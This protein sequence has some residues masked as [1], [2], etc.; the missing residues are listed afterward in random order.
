MTLFA[1]NLPVSKKDLDDTASSFGEAFAN[2][3]DA[4]RVAQGGVLGGN[5]ALTTQVLMATYNSGG[6]A[7]FASCGDGNVVE[8]YA[9]GADFSA[10]TVAHRFFMSKGERRTQGGLSNGAIFVSTKG[11]S[12][13]SNCADTNSTQN[14]AGVMPFGAE[15][16]ADRQFFFFAFRDSSQTGSGNADV[17]QVFVAA[18]AVPSVVELKNGTG[19]TTVAGPVSLEAFGFTTLQTNADA[20]FQVVATQPVFCAV[21]AEFRA[22]NSGNTAFEDM[23]LIPP[24]TTDLLTHVSNNRLSALYDNTIVYAYMQDGAIGR[25]TVSPGSPVSLYTGTINELGDVFDITSNATPATAGTFKLSL[26]SVDAAVLFSAAPNTTFNSFDGVV[27]SSNTI[28]RCSITTPSSA[29]TATP[30]QVIWESGGTGSGVSLILDS[31]MQLGLFAGAAA[32]SPKLVSTTALAVDTDYDII[33]ELISGTSL[34]IHVQPASNFDWWSSGRTPEYTTSD[35]TTDYA[36]TDGGGYGVQNGTFGGYSGSTSGTISFQGALNSDLAIFAN[37]ATAAQLAMDEITIPYDNAGV[38]SLFDTALGSDNSKV[39][40]IKGDSLADASAV[41]RVE[42]FGDYSRNSIGVVLD[43]SGL[44]GNAHT[45]SLRQ[46]GDTINNFGSGGS[47]AVN[48]LVRLISSGPISALSGA[49]GSGNEATYA[50]PTAQAYQLTAIPLRN[51]S[52]GNTA[53]SSGMTFLSYAEDEVKIY[54]SDGSLF[55]TEDM[56]R[57]ISVSTAAD[58]L[59]PAGVTITIDSDGT[60]A[61]TFSGGWAESNSPFVMIHNASNSDEYGSL[62]VDEVRMGGEETVYLG[63]TPEDIRA[64]IRKDADGILRARKI[65]A[66]GVETWEVI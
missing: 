24:L 62:P 34:N 54:N 37:T 60:P 63:I 42:L 46:A 55:A 17:G 50:F 33:V 66:S 47:Y 20:E 23:R 8:I 30:G 5:P 29:P 56:V 6:Y 32:G 26:S 3:N 13:V 25:M 65:D 10:G 31:S 59:H 44:T 48:D 2:L 9:S 58:Q 51:A 28:I 40:M 35:S 43:T 57:G 52:S 61:R 12:G 4:K 16:F 45:Y 21:C 22:D 1:P 49:D 39:Y 36:G 38:Q 64:E 18:G 14:D 27:E 7:Q 41:M 11:I 19:D 53:A 15:A